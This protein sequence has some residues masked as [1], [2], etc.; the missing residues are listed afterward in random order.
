MDQALFPTEEG[1]GRRKTVSDGTAG[2]A[3]ENEER[4]TSKQ[5][6]TFFVD[7][8]KTRNGLSPPRRVIGQLAKEIDVLRKEGHSDDV[9]EMGLEIL[10]DK[11]LDPSALAS[12]VF[13]AQSQLKGLTR[14]DRDLLQAFLKKCR[15]TTGVGWPTG[16]RWVRGVASGTFISDPLG[17]DKPMYPVPWGKPSRE[18]VVNALRE[19]GTDEH[20]GSAD[21]T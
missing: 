12:C 10:V 5:L 16:S 20:S 9:V 18:Q 3:T 17:M 6:V 15:D 21:P 2:A 7:T 8:A 1:S 4:K 19:G 11:G 14:A 13:T